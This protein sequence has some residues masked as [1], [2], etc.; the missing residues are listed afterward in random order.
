MVFVIVAKGGCIEDLRRVILINVS[1]FVKLV[2]MLTN[3][4]G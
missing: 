2:M 3:F 4:K 1:L